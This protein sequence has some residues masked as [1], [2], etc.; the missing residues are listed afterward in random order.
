MALKVF[1]VRE[2]FRKVLQDYIPGG[3]IIPD[4]VDKHA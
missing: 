2:L 1:P 4:F 3:F